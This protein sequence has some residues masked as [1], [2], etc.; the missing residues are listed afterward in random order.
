[1]TTSTPSPQVERCYQRVC[2]TKT[3][4]HSGE[5][6]YF[7]PD[8]SAANFMAPVTRSSSAP[9]TPSKG[10]VSAGSGGRG[11]SPRR[12]PHCTKCGRP[13][14]GH[15]RS[16][17]PYA[18]QSKRSSISISRDADP[19]D[20]MASS[21]S[22]LSIADPVKCKKRRLSV[23]FALIPAETL[24][25]LQE[26]GTQLVDVL[27]PTDVMNECGDEDRKAVLM[28][29]KSLVDAERLPHEP[30]G[31]ATVAME[32]A[33][34]LIQVTSPLL[35]RR[36]PGTLS[37]PTASFAAT[38]PLSDVVADRSI[39]MNETIFLLPGADV[40]EPQK[41][42]SLRRSMSAEQR[43]LF[44]QRLVEESNKAPATLISIPKADIQAVRQDAERAGFIVRILP[45]EAEDN[46]QWVMLGSDIQA[47][48]LL[49]EKFVEEDRKVAKAQRSGGF[50]IA[51]G[52]ALFGAVATWT[53]LAYA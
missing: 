2:T 42:R 46:Q 34:K 3:L 50:G 37:T 38:E 14:A 33:K 13:R 12:L 9:T 23:R 19:H 39:N 6:P 52:G 4:R 18:P 32:E 22:S 47:V 35:S 10:A 44:L 43:S 29:R 48:D 11:S 7:Y 53:G 30:N 41:S 26:D 24:A 31:H 20:A 51:A 15:P 27:F 40:K 1:M 49:G 21:F 28:W 16:G 36:M 25:S 17:C 45:G 8:G 5:D